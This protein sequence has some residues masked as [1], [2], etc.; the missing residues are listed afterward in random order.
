MVRNNSNWLLS[1]FV[2]FAEVLLCGSLFTSR[3]LLHALLDLLHA[4]LVLKAGTGYNHEWEETTDTLQKQR[5][6]F[7]VL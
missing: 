2:G 1:E 7:A 5:I 6:S 3:L 4:T